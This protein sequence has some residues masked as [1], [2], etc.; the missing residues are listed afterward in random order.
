[1]IAVLFEKL[2]W[3]GNK[4]TT[5]QRTMAWKTRVKFSLCIL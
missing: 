1:M 3:N 2:K 4:H 5:K